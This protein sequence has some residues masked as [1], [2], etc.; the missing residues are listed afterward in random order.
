M[1]YTENQYLWDKLNNRFDRDLDTLKERYD[2]DARMLMMGDASG[3]NMAKKRNRLW[4]WFDKKTGCN[5]YA[6]IIVFAFIVSASLFSVG[7]ILNVFAGSIYAGAGMLLLFAIM[8]GTGIGI[9]GMIFNRNGMQAGDF[10]DN[11]TITSPFFSDMEGNIWHQ[12]R[13][14]E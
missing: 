3:L 9:L 1:K 11:P 8:A 6:E 14:V 10:Y 12:R 7:L 13:D 5:V 2:R 4:M